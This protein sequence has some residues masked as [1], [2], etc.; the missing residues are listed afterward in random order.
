MICY[1]DL[2]DERHAKTQKY[3][4]PSLQYYMFIVRTVCLQRQYVVVSDSLSFHLRY[5]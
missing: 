1:R 4:T 3:M 2:K 5:E